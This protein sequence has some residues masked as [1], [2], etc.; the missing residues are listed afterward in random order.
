MKI[1]LLRS[2]QQR[3]VIHC[4]FL[5]TKI[6]LLRSFTFTRNSVW[7]GASFLLQVTYLFDEMEEWLGIVLLEVLQN[8]TAVLD[9]KKLENLFYYIF[10]N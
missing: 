5:S 6:E 4:K 9:L 2:Y 1:E 3:L 10:Y 8:G 7:Y